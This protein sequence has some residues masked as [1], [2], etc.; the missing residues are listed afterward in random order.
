MARLPGGRLLVGILSA[1]ASAAFAAQVL[2]ES[3]EGDSDLGAR[4][5]GLTVAAFIAFGAAVVSGL[6][7]R[8]RDGRELKRLLE[9]DARD[10]PWAGRGA[11]F[12]ASVAGAAF[13]FSL[14]AHA[15]EGAFDRGDITAWALCALVVALCAAFAA[16][17]VARAVPAVVVFIASALM[18]ADA[19]A[20]RLADGG[21]AE[22]RIAFGDAWPPT[23]F[24]RPPP[25]HV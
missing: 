24:N 18:R 4:A 7:Y 13:G 2:L 14:L 6:S 5:I 10:L 15:G 11:G 3:R 21:R 25:L 1:S 19:P 17:F 8:A 23:L 22:V 9:L 20:P 12:A 16:W